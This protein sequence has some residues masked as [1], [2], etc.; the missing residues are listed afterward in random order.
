MHRL[1]VSFD[2]DAHRLQGNSQIEV[3]ACTLTA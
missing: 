1:E 3:P 2:L